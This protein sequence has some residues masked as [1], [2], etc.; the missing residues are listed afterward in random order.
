MVSFTIYI[1]VT[2]TSCKNPDKG[3]LAQI[4]VITDTAEARQ[5]LTSMY[6]FVST[7]DLA[8]SFIFN[9][10]TSFFTGDFAWLP[11]K[12]WAPVP[13]DF[14][15]YRNLFKTNKAGV[16]GLTVDRIDIYCD[17]A[18]VLYHFHEA[19]HNIKTDEVWMD[20][21]HSAVAV[22]KKDATGKWRIAFLAYAWS[23]AYSICLS[24]IFLQ[25]RFSKIIRV[26]LYT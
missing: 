7:G 9:Q 5:A 12:E 17:L 10:F 19:V 21:M 18:Y 16:D 2:F 22:L 11:S 20:V 1:S 6:D 14:N 3:S 13:E 4:Q 24:Q 8:D 23:L 26:K 15:G 25:P